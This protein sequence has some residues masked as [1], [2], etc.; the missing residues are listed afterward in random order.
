MAQAGKQTRVSNIQH[1]VEK[2]WVLGKT[3]PEIAFMLLQTEG[4]AAVDLQKIIRS[5]GFETLLIIPK[6]NIAPPL[7]YVSVH[8]VCFCTKL[9][10]GA[11]R[12][13]AEF[14]DLYKEELQPE[15][16]LIVKCLH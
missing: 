13:E 4:Y 2:H 12:T 9:K 16:E 10:R 15:S 11:Q 14:I 5:V 1:V 6:S 3:G 7:L 8:P